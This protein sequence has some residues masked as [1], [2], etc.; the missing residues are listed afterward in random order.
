MGKAPFQQLEKVR[1]QRGFS[2]GELQ[3]FDFSLAIDHALNA[4]FQILQE[5]LRIKGKIDEFFFKN[6]SWTPGRL[7]GIIPVMSRIVS[8]CLFAALAL[9]GCGG[10]I[11][12]VPLPEATPAPLPVPTPLATPVPAPTPEPTPSAA[13]APPGE[14]FL[15]ERVGAMTPDGVRAF[16]AG[17]MVREVAPGLYDFDGTLQELDPRK[18]TNDLD[19]VT[20]MIVGH[21]A[22]EYEAY[23]ARL[24]QAAAAKATPAPAPVAVAATPTPT[25]VE[26]PTPAG[27][28]PPR[29][30]A[31]TP[32]PTPAPT[33]E[34]V[35]ERTY[36]TESGMR[37]RVRVR[38]GKVSD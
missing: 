19:K 27:T 21:R 26:K 31:S 30:A 9:S 2:A 36:D 6:R 16:P 5:T 38:G 15:L 29:T 34:Q 24:R 22:R 37:Y 18:V 25:P 11:G 4:G 14:F 10:P 8:I 23:Q 28:P 12:P 20:A 7:D 13:L 32:I 3:D 33:P 1:M 35:A 17:T